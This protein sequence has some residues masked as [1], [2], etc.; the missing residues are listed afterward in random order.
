MDN[1][2]LAIIK[3][4]PDREDI[5]NIYTEGFSPTGTIINTSAVRV[6]WRGRNYRVN[7]ALMV[8]VENN[9]LLISSTTAQNIENILKGRVC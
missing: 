6:R 8:E 1:V 7:N 4:W 3:Y 9:G 5:E 2:I